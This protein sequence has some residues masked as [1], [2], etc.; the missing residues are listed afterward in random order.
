MVQAILQDSFVSSWT[1]VTELEVYSR[2]QSLAGISLA[3][4]LALD[5]YVFPVQVLIQHPSGYVIAAINANKLLE[6]EL[7]DTMVS[8][9]FYDPAV[10]TYYKFLK[11]GLQEFREIFQE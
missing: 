6:A 8:E 10:Y 11:E 5:A 9:G 4:S 3:A 1:L 2:D 7:N